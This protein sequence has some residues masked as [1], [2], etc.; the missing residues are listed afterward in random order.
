MAAKL[1][2]MKDLPDICADLAYELLMQKS[3]SVKSPWKRSAIQFYEPAMMDEK[4]KETWEEEKI[5]K[6]L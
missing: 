5:K 1:K 2:D 6:Q 3:G 4:S